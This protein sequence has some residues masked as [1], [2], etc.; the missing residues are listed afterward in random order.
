[1]NCGSWKSSFAVARNRLV[2]RHVQAGIAATEEEAGRR[3]DE[4]DLMNG[5][6]IVDGRLEVQEI[7]VSREDE[8][9]GKAETLA[10]KSE[11]GE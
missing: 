8:G 1:M 7:V 2:T 9:W 6:E 5:R 10:E 11:I 4:N 3:A